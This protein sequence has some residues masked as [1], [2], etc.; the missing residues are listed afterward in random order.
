MQNEQLNA[1][2]QVGMSISKSLDANAVA[3][4]EGVY[5]VESIGPV[6]AYRSRYIALRDRINGKGFK[7]FLDKL[8][9]GRDLMSE[10]MQIPME[11]KFAD[12]IENIVVNVGKN[13][14]LDTYLAGA[15]YTVVGPYMGL[16]G[17]TPASA[18]ATDT[19]ATKT[20]WTEVGATNAPAYTAP[21]KTCA[22]S[23]AASGAKSLSSA[24]SFAITSAG[25]VAGCFIV[26]GSGAVS[27]V[28][29]TAGTLYSVGAFTGGSKAVTNGDTLNVTYTASL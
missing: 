19:M 4:A 21:R 28:D 6:E 23:A 14:A 24:L 8:I 3:A 25:T 20:G 5:K 2:E 13:L 27:T 7:A 29:S 22:W 12:V 15:A 16:A 26:F 10:F 1:D 18:V 9:N 17:G 11:Q